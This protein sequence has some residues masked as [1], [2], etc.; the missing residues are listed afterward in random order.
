MCGLLRDGHILKATTAA[1]GA[2]AIPELGARVSPVLL[3]V[4][5]HICTSLLFSCSATFER[6]PEH[7]GEG[8]TY[9]TALTHH[10][11]LDQDMHLPGLKQLKELSNHV[12]HSLRLWLRL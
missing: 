12:L 8:S 5:L 11:A 6:T 3:G 2:T 10:Y 4:S 9:T 7:T 1:G